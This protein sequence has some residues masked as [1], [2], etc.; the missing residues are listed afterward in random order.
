MVLWCIIGQRFI[1]I[2]GLTELILVLESIHGCVKSSLDIKSI[3]LE[4]LCHIVSV[5]HYKTLCLHVW[6]GSLENLLSLIVF[7]TLI[8]DL[9]ILRNWSIITGNSTSN[10]VLIC[11]I[12]SFS[13]FGVNST[14][15]SSSGAWL[16]CT[17]LSSHE[18]RSTLAIVF[19]L[20]FI[21]VFLGLLFWFLL[22]SINILDVS[23][24]RWG[25][26][27]PSN[28]ILT[29]FSWVVLCPSRFG[30]DVMLILD[31]S[32]RLYLKWIY[33]HVRFYFA[34]NLNCSCLKWNFDF[35][36]QIKPIKPIWNE[37]TYRIKIK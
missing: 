29:C 34:L 15:W 1:V 35:K 3:W 16:R 10:W 32:M 26:V 13:D 22:S 9:F 27:F 19:G 23:T 2:L 20:P 12:D 7:A 6:F 25:V 24:S 8:T 28:T 31:L 4:L 14:L 21:R 37:L 33:A 30:S 11:S 17:H 36:L 18:L 5:R